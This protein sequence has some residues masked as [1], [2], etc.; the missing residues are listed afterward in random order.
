MF[1]WR[2]PDISNQ[3]GLTVVVEHTH[4]HTQIIKTLPL[5]TLQRKLFSWYGILTPEL[6]SM[7]YLLFWIKGISESDL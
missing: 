6:S 2:T 1:C 5:R 3:K 7:F 4:T